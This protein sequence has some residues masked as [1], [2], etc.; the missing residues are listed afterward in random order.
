MR[1]RASEEAYSPG[2]EPVGTEFRFESEMLQ[3]AKDWLKNLGM[4][5]RAEFETPW[6]ICDL[7]GVSF[8]EEHVDARLRQ[9]QRQ[10]LGPPSRIALFCQLPDV[11]TGTFKTIARL[12][13]ELSAWFSPEEI[14]RELDRLESWNYVIRPQRN[15]YQKVNGWLPLHK[16]IIALELKLR[17]VSEALM[18]AFSHTRF[19]RSSYVGLPESVAERVVLG[20][21]ADFEALGIGL[22]SVSAGGCDVL[23]EPS[24]DGHLLDPVLE[25]HCVERFWRS[26]ITGSS[27]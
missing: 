18:Q 5:T 13:R 10:P 8:D 16:H 22:V 11:G 20:R 19:T 14:R 4:S 27:S 9:R 1:A 7:V 17:R 21:R 3:P 2:R 12:E 23:L 15:G 26:R 24:N 6:G 25:M